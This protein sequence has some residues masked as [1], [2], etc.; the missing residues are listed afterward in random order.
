MLRRRLKTMDELDEVE[1]KERQERENSER[2]SCKAFAVILTN[3]ADLYTFNPTLA[4]DQLFLAGLGFV[5]GIPLA[6]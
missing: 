5:N 4:L 1:E 2:I 6:S 3:S